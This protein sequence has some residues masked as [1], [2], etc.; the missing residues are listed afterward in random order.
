MIPEG[1][2]IYD[3]VTQTLHWD[4]L[5]ILIPKSQQ[6]KLLEWRIKNDL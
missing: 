1:R 3:K 6:Q 5:F 2:I 4:Q